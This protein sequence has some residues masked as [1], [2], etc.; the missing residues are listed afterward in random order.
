MQTER[1]APSY[2]EELNF[3]CNVC[4]RH[5]FVVVET[6]DFYADEDAELPPPMSQR[7]VILLNKAQQLED[8]EEEEA[9]AAEGE[10]GKQ[11]VRVS[12]SGKQKI[13]T[14]PL[15][16]RRSQS[17]LSPSWSNPLNASW[18]SGFACLKSG[19]GMLAGPIEDERHGF[20]LQ[21]TSNMQLSNAES[22]Q[23]Y[24]AGVEGQVPGFIVV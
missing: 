9:A 17:L 4:C 24:P 3:R 7:D 11:K 21:C 6:I 16:N 20:A 22:G 14:S 2:Y 23:P 1:D 19:P 12:P 15:A 5:D 10:A 8:E 13:K 18:L